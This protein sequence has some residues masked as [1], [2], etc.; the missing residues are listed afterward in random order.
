MLLLGGP[1]L[2]GL[3][4]TRPGLLPHLPPRSPQ[5]R[6]GSA[7]GLWQAQQAG[8]G[9]RGGLHREAALGWGWGEGLGPPPV[10]PPLGSCS[11]EP[12]GRGHT[13]THTYTYPTRGQAGAEPACTCSKADPRR[14]DPTGDGDRGPVVITPRFGEPSSSAVR[15]TCDVLGAGQMSQGQE[16]VCACASFRVGTSGAEWLF[17]TEGVTTGS[18]GL[19]LCM[20]LRPD[21]AQEVPSL[22]GW[23]LLAP[24]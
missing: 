10:A 24:G 23:L 13:H 16:R 22:G 17:V 12:R 8:K 20:S 3:S 9:W 11:R 6:R 5:G 19:W 2:P 4:R 7:E 18:P 15:V 14:R 21:Q 1:H